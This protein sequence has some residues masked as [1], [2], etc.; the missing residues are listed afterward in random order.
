MQAK[1]CHI[2]CFMHASVMSDV[3][4][5]TATQVWSYIL[6]IQDCVLQ[7]AILAAAQPALA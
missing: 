1:G 7:L 3:A 4:R 2:E 6:N 5:L